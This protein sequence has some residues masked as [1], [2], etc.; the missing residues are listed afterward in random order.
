M[1]REIHLFQSTT[2]R[3]SLGKVVMII[4]W[5]FTQRW[6]VHV[7]EFLEPSLRSLFN[8]G[9]FSPLPSG[10]VLLLSKKRLF[11]RELVGGGLGSS[12]EQRLV[13]EPIFNS[14]NT[15]KK[16][17]NLRRSSLRT[18]L[19][20]HFGVSPGFSYLVF[21]A[22][23][24]QSPQ[25]YSTFISP[26]LRLHAGNTALQTILSVSLSLGSHFT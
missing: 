13:T 19:L 1:V 21:Q 26:K 8:L 11:E 17:I 16:M 23:G 20:Q 2:K 14:N 4:P 7:L 12:L 25:S 6:A 22:Y 10:P 15:I 18:T 24:H 5:Y 3:S 9:S